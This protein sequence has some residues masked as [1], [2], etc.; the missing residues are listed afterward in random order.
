MW[1]HY[2]YMES[3]KPYFKNDLFLNRQSRISKIIIH[4][5]KY[6]CSMKSFKPGLL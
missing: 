1:K 5:I 4:Q 3:F 2:E 6:V